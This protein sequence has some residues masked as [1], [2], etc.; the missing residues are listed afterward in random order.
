MAAFLPEQRG[1]W[2]SF[3][4]NSHRPNC[5][6]PT[7]ELG[8]SDRTASAATFTIH[9][10]ASSSTPRPELPPDPGEIAFPGASGRARAGTRDVTAR[11]RC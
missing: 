4:M 2:A 9:V 1:T 5:S 7:G 11:R 10:S 6:C 8:C 3:P